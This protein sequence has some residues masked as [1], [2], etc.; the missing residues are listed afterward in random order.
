MPQKPP[1]DVSPIITA[2]ARKYRLDPA[3]VLAVARGEGG[4]S[5]GAVG[6]GGHAFGPFQLNNAGGV[7]TGR[8]GNHA[9]FA[10][11]RAGLEFALSGMAKAGAAGLTGRAAVE[12]IIRNYERPADKETSVRNALARLGSGRVPS[13]GAADPPRQTAGARAAPGM[14]APSVPSEDPRRQLLFSLIQARR[15]GN[16]DRSPIIAALQNLQRAPQVAPA[17][18]SP[19]QPA[20]PPPP[21]PPAR[22]A[23]AVGGRPP[24]GASLDSLLS[25]YGLADA[26]TSGDR[27]GAITARGGRSDHGRKGKARDIDHRDPD[28]PRIAA[29][30]K[31][32][33]GAFKDF[34]FSGL[35]WFIDEGRLHPIGQLNKTDRGNHRDHAHLSTR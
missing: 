3:A 22:A 8:P 16:S 29:Y 25:Q 24:A 9:A 1:R 10:N 13:A 23:A 31:A 14:S 28:F 27:P 35:P 18:Q 15:S 30:A 12:R 5:Y 21:P 19:R 26:V 17:A 4:T 2:L 6:D 34:I 20:P 32:N 33:P 7:L 11:S